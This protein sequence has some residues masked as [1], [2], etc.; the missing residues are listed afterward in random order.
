MLVAFPGFFLGLLLAERLATHAL[1]FN[2]ASPFLW[3]ASLELRGLYGEFSN[4]LDLVTGFELGIQV[5]FISALFIAFLLVAQTKRG[6]AVCFLV[7]HLLLLASAFATLIAT[8]FQVASFDIASQA[9]NSSVFT[10]DFYLNLPQ[11]VALAAGIAGSLYSHI[12]LLS[13]ARG[14]KA[15]A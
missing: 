3:R 4:R 13:A 11:S 5:A 6:P 1:A 12:V 7:N 14:N 8:N 2:P 9:T 15:R 10:L